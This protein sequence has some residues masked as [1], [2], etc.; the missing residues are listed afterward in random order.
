MPKNKI[1][2]ELNPLALTYLTHHHLP[3]GH[4][5]TH[6]F[7]GP[8]Q[9]SILPIFLFWVK[10]VCA[11]IIWKLDNLPNLIILRSIQNKNKINHN[12]LETIK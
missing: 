10:F 9:L 3:Q 5:S 8:I 11:L 7:L 2:E 12:V 4:P 6:N 1:I